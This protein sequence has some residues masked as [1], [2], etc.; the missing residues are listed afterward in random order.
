MDLGKDGKILLHEGKSYSRQRETGEQMP[1]LG[2]GC[3]RVTMEKA[4]VDDDQR[5]P[6][7]SLQFCLT[8]NA[9]V[10]LKSSFLTRENT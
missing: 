3:D 5:L 7:P 10:T 8:Q 1:W 2:Q 6:S 9:T 4:K